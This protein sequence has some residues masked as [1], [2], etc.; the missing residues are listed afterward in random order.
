MIKEKREKKKANNNLTNNSV[1]TSSSNNTNDNMTPST[2][3]EQVPIK[4]E[5]D[6]DTKKIKEEPGEDHIGDKCHSPLD[7]KPSDLPD[8]KTEDL[9]NNPNNAADGLTGGSELLDSKNDLL[10]PDGSMCGKGINSESVQPLPSNVINKQPGTM[11]AQYM[12]QQ[13]QIF[14]F[15]TQLANKAADC[16]L[17]GQY[18]SIISYHC[19]QPKTKKYLEK[20]PLKINQFNRQNSNQWLNS[21]V[22][23]KKGPMKGPLGPRDSFKSNMMGMGGPGHMGM[24][25]PNNNMGMGGM[26]GPGGMMQGMGPGN[27]MGPGPRGMGPGGP[28]HGG[29]MHSGPG[30]PMHSGPGGPMH[31]GPG[32]PMHSGPG[33]PIHPGPGGPMHSGPG[34]PMH[35][36]PGGPLHSGPGGPMH[37]G[38]GGPMHPGPGGPMHSG[39]G[40]PM[41]SGPGGPMHSGPG[42]PMHSGLGG[43]M[44]SGPG[45]NMHSGP[46]GP[47]HSGPG[48]PMHS[49]PGGNMHSGPGGPMHGGPGGMGGHGNMNSGPGCMPPGM[50]SGPGPENMNTGSGPANMNPCMGNPR[51]PW[52]QGNMSMDNF[53]MDS[54]QNNM[55]PGGPMKPGGPQGH[56]IG[57]PSQFM[58]NR[59]PNPNNVPPMNNSNSNNSSMI[60]SLDDFNDDSLELNQHA[61]ISRVK[62]PDEDLTPQQRQHREEQLATLRKMHELLFSSRENQGNMAQNPNGGNGSGPGPN[63]NMGD[64][65]TMSSG[66]PTSTSASG[67]A[68]R[69]DD[70]LNSMGDSD[71]QKMQIPF[72]DERNKKENPAPENSSTSKGRGT[73][74]N[75]KSQGPP[76]SYHQATR[77]ASVPVA[78]PSPGPG[79]PNNPTSNLS[80][81]SPRTCSAL[82]LNSPDSRQSPSASHS[83][84]DSPLPSSR[85]HNPSNHGSP[86]SNKT[87]PSPSTKKDLSTLSNEFS[88]AGHS[89]PE[90]SMF[91]RSLQVL[92]Q[93]QKNSKEPDLMSVPSPQHIQNFNT[94]EGQELTIQKQP[95]T[96]LNKESSSTTSPSQQCGPGPNLDSNNPPEMSNKTS[97]SNPLTPTSSANEFPPISS[98]DTKMPPQSRFNCPS[99]QQQMSDS[100]FPSQ[101]NFHPG[102]IKTG[103]GGS[104]MGSPF[105]NISPP[106]SSKPCAMIC[107]PKDSNFFR[108]GPDHIPLNPD[109][110]MERKPVHFDPISS[111]AQMS[112]QLTS[113]VSGSPM[114]PGGPGGNMMGPGGAHGRMGFNGPGGPGPMH[115]MQM[116]DLGMCGPNMMMPGDSIRMFGP[117]MGPGRSMSPKMGSYCGPG[118]PGGMRPG[119]PVSGAPGNMYS[120]ANVQVKANA[121]NTISYLP[122]RPQGP[123]PGP[124]G[125]PNLDFL[126]RFPNPLSNLDS[127]VPTHKFQYF[128]N[129]FPPQNN[130]GGGG[131][132]CDMMN[133]N[134]PPGMMGPRGPNMRPMYP[135]PG[136]NMG[137]KGPS[138]LAPDASQPLP[139]SMGQTNLKNSNYIGP[140]TSDPN[141]AQ[142]FHNF[143]QQLYATSSRNQMP[144]PGGPGLPPQ[145][146]MPAQHQ[147]FFMPK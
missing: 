35:S 130:M 74:K 52:N 67:G 21:L 143:Q 66:P 116:N 64:P 107:D 60:P 84:L 63:Q 30:G 83:N 132:M 129:S 5:Q 124:R 68:Q 49:G 9:L 79:S 65:S 53:M 82:G 77:S 6:D 98:A 144:G 11:E 39:P 50:N 15:S 28:M 27:M 134:T 118:G 71:W 69:M 19:A 34:G 147:Q 78:I 133:C 72:F 138:G 120:G 88:P 58:M 142:Q 104:A 2:D 12:Q 45:G 80:L 3:D 56:M 57:G 113:T 44:H 87:H 96:S 42:G 25:G 99:P 4:T 125:Q 75:Q 89:D 97:P 1:A 136:P 114:G 31:S 145:Q 131:G 13:S 139:P 90:D 109:V 81:P 95:N 18:P 105:M 137:P 33:G 36:G 20:H 55:G 23:M 70:M 38:P 43:Q 127:K 122:T 40:G 128:P 94:F 112:Q 7:E 76:P 10:L 54:C 103:P 62:V 123:D 17:G 119:V 8:I 73:T 41:H 135:G 108:V 93:D 111:L 100:R 47:M 110:N 85:S 14:V 24:G 46:G 29:S 37:P 141:Y 51:M 59:P 61:S 126:Q 102:S 115:M 146:T 121:P 91:S 117:D 32:G 140:T 106:P 92:A 86:V 16:V 101:N 26:C 22:H 48:G